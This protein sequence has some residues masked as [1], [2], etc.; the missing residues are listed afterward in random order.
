KVYCKPV[1]LSVE[2]NQRRESIIARID[3]WHTQK[4]GVGARKLVRQL[5]NEGF[6][7][8]RKLVRRLMGEMG[9]Q[10]I[11]PKANLSKRNFQDTIVPYLL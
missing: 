5:K 7:V 1:E 10:A 9:I 6:A 11:Y 8:G 4:P 3:Y 2:E